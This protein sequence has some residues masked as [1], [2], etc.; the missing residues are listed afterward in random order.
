MRVSPL[1]VLPIILAEFGI[2]DLRESQ[3]VDTSSLFINGAAINV[4]G[5]CLAALHPRAI[6]D[7]PSSRVL[8]EVPG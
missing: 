5:A 2:V 8:N 1:L 6:N 7:G 4:S 3:Y